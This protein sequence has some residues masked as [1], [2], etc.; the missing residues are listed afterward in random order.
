MIPVGAGLLTLSLPPAVG[1]FKS[2][3]VGAMCLLFLFL[4]AY[5]A[6]FERSWKQ[7]YPALAGH[8]FTLAVRAGFEPAVQSYPYGSL[9]NY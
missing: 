6:G 3:K 7:K 5:K 4:S 1:G 9:A 2:N 8:S